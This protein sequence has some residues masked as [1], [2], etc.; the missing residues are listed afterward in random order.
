MDVKKLPHWKGPTH[1]RISALNI[2]DEGTR[3]LVLKHGDS[4]RTLKARVGNV[5]KGLISVE[6]L[7]ASGHRVVFD[8][9]DS[10]VEHKESGQ[11]IRIRR[12][13]RVFEAEFEV[14]PFEIAK[15]AVQAMNASPFQRQAHEL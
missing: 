8:G 15:L 5:N 9:D 7:V 12:R 1:P 6:E 2:V 10:F 13:N 11:V 14:V 3:T 4:L